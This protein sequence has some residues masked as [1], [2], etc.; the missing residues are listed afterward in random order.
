MNLFV[1]IAIEKESTIIRKS[2]L[3]YSFLF[4]GKEEKYDKFIL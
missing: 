3:F 2:N 1:Y 4:R